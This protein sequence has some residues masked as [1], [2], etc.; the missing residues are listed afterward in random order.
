MGRAWLAGLLAGGLAAGC[1]S[2]GG[3]ISGNAGATGDLSVT[4]TS[5]AA[6][7]TQ[8]PVAAPITITFDGVVGTQSLKD[9]YF[10]LT[11]EDDRLVPG[12][13]RVEG[14]GRT[15]VFVP[16]APLP[17]ATDHRFLVT[18]DVGDT[19]NRILPRP[20]WFTFRTLDLEPP[21][22]VAS[23]VGPG[24]E[25]VDRRDP[26][27][28]TFNEP[29]KS[30]S[31]KA[32]TV[33]LKDRFGT[34]V[35]L[36]LEVSGNQLRIDAIPDLQGSR[37]YILA[38]L[39]G[40]SGVADRAGNVLAVT[41]SIRFRTEADTTPPQLVSSWPAHA[42]TGRS[43]L[44]RPAFT[45]DES[46]DPGSYEPGGIL[47]QDEYANQVLFTLSASLDQRTIRIVPLAP[48][49]PERL[50]RVTFGAGPIAL[51]D[52]SGNSLPDTYVISFRTGSDSTPPAVSSTFPG[53]GATSISPNFVARASFSEPIDPASVTRDTV[54]L[55]ADGTP[56][57]VTPALSEDGLSLTIVPAVLAPPSLRHTL[58]LSG[59]MEGLH[60]VAGNPLPADVAV[61][62][63]TSPDPGIPEVL[64]APADGSVAVPV[65][66]RIIALFDVPVDPATVNEDSFA[67]L[68]TGAGPLAGERTVERGGRVIVFRPAGGLPAGQLLDLKVLA[69]PAGVRTQTGNWLGS[70][71]TAR[72][73]VGQASDTTAPVL[74]VTLDDIAPQRNQALAVPPSGFTIDVDAYDAGDGTLD[75]STLDLALSGPGPV[76]T[77][78][79]LFAVS[80]VGMRYAVTEV[81]ARLGLA[82]GAYVLN[83]TVRDLS[84]NRSAPT[85]Y[86]FEV[87]APNHDQLPFERTQVVWVRFDTDREGRGKGDGVADFDQDLLALGLLAAGDP[88]GRNGMLRKTVSD[89]ILAEAS[90]LLA[91]NPDGT[92]KAD[93]VAV[94][95]TT[96]LPA[97][98]HMQIAVGGQDPEAPRQRSYGEDSTGVLGRAYFDYRNS[99][100]NENNAGTSPGLGVFVGELFLYEG[101]VFKDLYPFYVTS[102]GRTYRV[103]SPHMGGTPAGA[104][105]LDAVVLASG[106]SYSAATPEQRL[107]HDQIFGA[108]D[109][110]AT[111]MG[112]ILAH[113]VGHSIGLVAEG[114]PPSGLHGDSSLHNHLTMLGDVM[115]AY[116]A[117]DTL[118]GVEHRFR[119][120]NLAY[121]RQRVIC[122]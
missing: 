60:D 81:P 61:S 37:E 39:G 115:G 73:R 9:D 8:V 68:R 111:A 47:L 44:L 22:V 119:D 19:S 122:K 12:S 100:P 114:P 110:L 42:S 89:G 14:G 112:I 3:G 52:V 33:T 88:A 69:G 50:Y 46:M 7:A 29:L 41:W 38:V 76:P 32:S 82:P 71:A 84:G 97:S 80:T 49:T 53:A 105:P 101:K 13:L 92:P 104:G 5:P 94:R 34:P 40:T 36:D 67:V 59:G 63:T 43:P 17:V 45:F 24:A 70:D 108:A 121:L 102:F 72:V 55:D 77:P 91:R 57:Y 2:G 106:F 74:E 20:Y 4:A 51:T 117:W 109:E 75:M 31:V 66:S 87:V 86:A 28:V 21:T 16:D 113:E 64:I 98:V 10:Q 58:K 99:K 23:T 107:R 96:N 35:V 27:L 95:F 85:A 56:V 90:R 83:A 79:D 6:E 15:V 103:L 1:G 118:I 18:E 65:N 78:D 48:L 11:G 25:G 62:W 120:L 26:I 93:S 54:R 116:V 30:S